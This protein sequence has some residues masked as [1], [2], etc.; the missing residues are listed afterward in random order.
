MGKDILTYISTVGA[1]LKSEFAR[2]N[3]FKRTNMASNAH[4]RAIPWGRIY[5]GGERYTQI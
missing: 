3:T 4:N 1:L 2:K 5:R